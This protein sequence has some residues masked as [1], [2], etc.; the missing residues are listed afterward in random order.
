M[1]YNASYPLI[2]RGA[3]GPTSLKMGSFRRRVAILQTMLKFMCSS[4]DSFP[5]I[6]CA[7]ASI[8]VSSF[9]QENHVAGKCL[10]IN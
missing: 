3:C 5:R 7:C 6:P 9:D 4:R 8:D 2:T 10:Y 1:I